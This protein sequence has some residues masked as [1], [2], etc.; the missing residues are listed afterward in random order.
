MCRQFNGFVAFRK[1][2]PKVKKL[3]M[4]TVLVGLLFLTSCSAEV[5]DKDLLLEK[6]EFNEL[7]SKI[8]TYIDQNILENGVYLINTNGK[9]YLFLSNRS[10]VVG[11]AGG[12]FT[13]V[14]ADLSDDKLMIYFDEN[15]VEN[16]N[17]EE[18]KDNRVIYLIHG[19]DNFEYILLHRN[20]IEIPFDIVFGI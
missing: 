13:N 6:I 20:G 19:D 16:Y 17:D 15:Y 11:E 3:L 18:V 9:Q 14:Y 4:V 8:E 5:N 12:Y 2:R 7:D 10:L 1:W